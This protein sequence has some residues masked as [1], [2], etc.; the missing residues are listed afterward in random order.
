MCSEVFD[1]PPEEVYERV[2][3]TNAYYGGNRPKGSRI[4]FVN[5]EDFQT[6]SVGCLSSKVPARTAPDSKNECGSLWMVTISYYSE[7]FFGSYAIKLRVYVVC[8]NKQIRFLNLTASTGSQL[9]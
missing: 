8:I 4:I 3:F 2:A 9:L 5:G 1:I 7:L 6:Q